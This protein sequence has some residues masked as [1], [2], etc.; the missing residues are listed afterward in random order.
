M[1]T[2]YTDTLSCILCACDKASILQLR[3]TNKPLRHEIDAYIRFVSTKHIF[4][5]D[6][7][8]QNLTK[9]NLMIDFFQ[10]ERILP[11][12]KCARCKQT[13][14]W[15]GECR[16]CKRARTAFPWKHA[17]AGPMG[18]ALIVGVILQ[19][20]KFCL[21]FITRNAVQTSLQFVRKT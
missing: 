18:A 11:S 17:I 13:V 12:Y 2:L 1:Y 8:I 21:H 20:S 6:F 16:S 19:Q 4:E 15:I 7:I 9:K 3:L 10:P 14:V 5:Y